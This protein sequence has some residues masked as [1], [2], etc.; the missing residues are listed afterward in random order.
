M[1]EDRS[2]GNPRYLH[3]YI[4][5]QTP[6]WYVFSNYIFVPDYCVLIAVFHR[7]IN[8]ACCARVG[9]FRVCTM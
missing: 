5:L 4:N 6:T 2:N 8:V 7:N 3:I 1:R 9:N